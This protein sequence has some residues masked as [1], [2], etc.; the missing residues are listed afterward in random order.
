MAV[1]I[2]SAR[3]GLV[4]SARTM[5]ARIAAL[6]VFMGS[7]LNLNLLSLDGRGEVTLLINHPL[8]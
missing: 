6:M 3:A 2:F 8:S 7:A 5:I 4:T 1:R